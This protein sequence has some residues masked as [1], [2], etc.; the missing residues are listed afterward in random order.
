[1]IG[2]KGKQKGFTL[3]ELGIGIAVLVIALVLG[4]ILAVYL[5]DLSELSRETIS[6]TSHLNRVLEKG[7][8]LADQSLTN[9][10]GYDWQNWFTE[11]NEQTRDTLGFFDQPFT[12]IQDGQGA[13]L[14]S[15]AS[16]F[17]GANPVTATFTISWLHKSKRT[18]TMQ[19]ETIYVDRT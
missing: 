3:V 1:M 2:M 8:E 16:N 19:G 17:Q 18:Y 14:E 10:T 9:L 5:I 12:L 11:Q 6:V 4:M 15:L 7:R 13:S